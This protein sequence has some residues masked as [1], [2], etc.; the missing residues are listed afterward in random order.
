M[1]NSLYDIHHLATHAR[2]QKDNSK[3]KPM[4]GALK[5]TLKKHCIYITTLKKSCHWGDT[6]LKATSMYTLGT[7]MNL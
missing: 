3:Q 1:L 6:L 5:P 2:S 7:N 4:D